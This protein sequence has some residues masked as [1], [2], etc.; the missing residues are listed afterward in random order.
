MII[1]INYL[2][3]NYYYARSHVLIILWYHGY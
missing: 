3:N 1:A 2:I